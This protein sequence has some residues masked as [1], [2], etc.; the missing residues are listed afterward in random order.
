MSPGNI[1]TSMGHEDANQKHGRS[2]NTVA[3]GGFFGA[4][5]SQNQ[6][7]NVSDRLQAHAAMRPTLRNMSIVRDQNDAQTAGVRDVSEHLEGAG[8]GNRVQP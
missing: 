8:L 7:Q 4:A 3:L 5:L 1:L 2:V 6:T